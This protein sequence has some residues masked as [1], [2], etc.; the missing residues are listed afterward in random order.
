MSR[1]SSSEVSIHGS[2]Q[3]HGIGAE[4]LFQFGDEG[5]GRGDTVIVAEQKDR[6]AAVVE[7]QMEVGERLTAMAA[8]QLLEP[9]EVAVGQ[10]RVRGANPHLADRGGAAGGQRAQFGED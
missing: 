8:K 2:P 10:A 5:L 1:S 4:Q 7:A 9:F 6:L 3:L